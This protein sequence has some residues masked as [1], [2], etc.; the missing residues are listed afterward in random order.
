MSVTTTPPT[1]NTAPTVVVIVGALL[2]AVV[3]LTVETPHLWVIGIGLV[4][5]AFLVG[6]RLQRGDGR[7]WWPWVLAAGALAKLGGAYVRYWVLFDIYGGAGDAVRYHEDGRAIADLWRTLNVPSLADA[8]IGSLGTKV[9]ALGTGLVYT[10]FEPS[11]LGGFFLFGTLAFAGQVLIVLAVR[12]RHPDATFRAALLVLF[13]PTLVYWPSSVGKDA[14][15]LLGLG[16][17]AYGAA[18]LV[19]GYLTRWAVVAGL[20]LLLM[21]LIRPHV[22]GLSIAAFAVASLLARAPAGGPARLRRVVLLGLSVVVA[23]FMLV[24]LGDQLGFDLEASLET[25]TLDPVVAEVER[26]TE[27]GGSAVDAEAV[28]GVADIPGAVIRVLFRP[29]PQEADN[30]QML[31]TSAEGMLL[32][33]LLLWRSPR[34]VP[35]LRTLRRQP[36][37]LFCLAYVLGF[38]VAWSAILNYGILARQ[39]SAMVP[40][41][42]AF[43]AIA[44]WKSQEPDDGL[45]S[46][47]PG[48]ELSRSSAGR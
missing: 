45:S 5:G 41:L 3:G 43:V 37:V 24:R 8:G 42:L 25:G 44:G 36:F 7:G 29:F 34:W 35:A 9:T 15:I 39:R 13:W 31:A 23:G 19:E 20:G 48:T 32:I 1:M 14:L 40:F 11:I 28:E 17:F 30:A 10:P 6:R 38:G 18:R 21:G 26:R 27:T 33:A 2:A 47:P 46:P 12:A 22:A 4:A 16:I